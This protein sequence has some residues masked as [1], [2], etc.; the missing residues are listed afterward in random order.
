MKGGFCV[1]MIKEKRMTAIFAYTVLSIVAFITLIPII[2]CIM[3]SFKTNIEIMASPENM[4]PEEFTFSNYIEVFN[5][6]SF[7]VLRM[8]WNSTYYTIFSVVINLVLSSICGYVFARGNFAGKNT[9]FAVF[10]SLMFI[11]MGTITIYPKFQ[12]LSVVNLNRSLFGLMALKFFGI[13]IVNMYLVRGYILSLPK[14]MD[15]AARIDGC[16]YFRI[17]LK[18][19]APLL[20]PILATIGILSFQASWNEYL[21]PAI[22]TMGIPEQTPLIAGIVALKTSGGAASQ[23][24]LMFAGMTIA[25]VPVLFAYVVANKHFVSGI[26]AGA[27]KG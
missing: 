22:F 6:D 7:N 25:I 21:M 23:W 18:I 8:L 4:I 20:K 14:E 10:T 27:V 11:N 24:N 17:F 1:Y 2:Y 13:P 5:S 3:S 26:A 15:E 19:T 16:D 12:I 9:I